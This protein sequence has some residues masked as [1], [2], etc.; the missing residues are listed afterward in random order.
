MAKTPKSDGPH[1]TAA[2]DASRPGRPTR[3]GRIVP[4]ATPPVKPQAPVP[5][6]DH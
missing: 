6:A 2:G 3:T 1:T 5:M 4:A